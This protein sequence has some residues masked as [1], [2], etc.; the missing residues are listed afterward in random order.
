MVEQLFAAAVESA[1][2]SEDPKYGDA[3]RCGTALQ[4]LATSPTKEAAINAVGASQIVRTA[5]I[6]ESPG[7]AP[8]VK[9]ADGNIVEASLEPGQLNETDPELELLNHGFPDIKGTD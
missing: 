9:E 8:V 3:A 4:T 5:N 7:A 1:A 2:K 6:A